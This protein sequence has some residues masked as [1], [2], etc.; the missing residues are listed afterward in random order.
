[1]AAA[2]FYSVIERQVGYNLLT[3]PSFD[4]LGKSWVAKT[5]IVRG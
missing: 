3:R 2:N 4:T 5:Y 1:M